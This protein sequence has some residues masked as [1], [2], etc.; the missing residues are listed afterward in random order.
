MPNSTGGSNIRRSKNYCGPCWRPPP[1]SKPS[2]WTRSPLT[3]SIWGKPRKNNLVRM[4]GEL[5]RARLFSL[6]RWRLRPGLLVCR[7]PLQNSQCKTLFSRCLTADWHGV[8]KLHD[9]D[10]GKARR[11]EEARLPGGAY[12][13]VGGKAQGVYVRTR[14][15][16]ACFSRCKSES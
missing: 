3:R 16:S 13:R 15:T 10:V 4:R 6:P 9:F 2:T 14:S 1:R 12:V 7:K 8:Q 11:F 5:T